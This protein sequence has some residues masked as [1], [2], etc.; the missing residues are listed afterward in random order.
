MSDPAEQ[1]PEQLRSMVDKKA[2]ELME[3]ADSVQIFITW[4]DGGSEVT[5]SYETGK[6]NFYARQGQI[7]EWLRIQH[8][9]QRNYAVRK[10]QQDQ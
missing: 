6:G 1:L 10:D 9:F 4:H 8:Q 3:H 7:D 5:K 2:S